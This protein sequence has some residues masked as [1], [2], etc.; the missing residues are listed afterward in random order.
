MSTPAVAYYRRSTDRQEQ[1]IPDQRKAVEAYAA[2]HEYKII[3]E[4]VDDAVSG[5]GVAGR[6]G[7]LRMIADAE[8]GDF[9]AALVYDLSRFGR[10]DN[11]ETGHYRWMLRE[12]G[13]E[14]V[15]TQDDLGEGDV[16]EI[17]RPIMQHQKHKFVVDMSRDIARG[18]VSTAGDGRRVGG[19]APYGFT[20]AEVDRDGNVV[21]VL[22]VGDRK[23]RDEHQTTL[24][25]G[26]TE[27]VAVIKGIFREFLAGKGYRM[28]ALDLNAR[29]IPSV[30]GNGWA[31]TTI[32]EIVMNA[33]YT[34][35]SVWN[36]R[37]K[38]KFY[39]VN[40]GK[41]ERCP[42]RRGQRVR[43]NDA[44]EWVVRRDAHPAVIGR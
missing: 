12:R 34:G 39:E 42:R 3:R 8:A 29:G 28:I 16:A 5:T 9:E 1:S 10:M 20:R 15:Y 41:P 13:V 14:V 37:P 25:L 32:R 26:D 40:G 6:A 27:K 18:M 24:V 19:R 30:K 43:R 22:E 36:K 4:Y 31:A 44:A 33:A 11:D 2:E 21:R 38:G 7:F 17:V 35:D 23:G